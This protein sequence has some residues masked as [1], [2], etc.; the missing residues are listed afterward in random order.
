M[1]KS[2]TKFAAIILIIAVS[3]IC[4]PV[5]AVGVS[6]S[7]LELGYSPKFPSRITISGQTV[8]IEGIPQTSDYRYIWLWFKV[9]GSETKSYSEIVE[10]NFDGTAA[11]H[12]SNLTSGRYYLELFCAGER[13]VTYSSIVWGGDVQIQWYGNS[14]AFIEPEMY[15]HNVIVS[16][17]KRDDLAALTYYLSQSDAIQS[18]NAEIKQLANQLT[19]GITDNYEKAVVIHDWLCN[20]I[21]YDYDAYYKRTGYGDSSALGT[22]RSKIS[23]CEG[24]A[25]LN[26][27]LLRAAG[28]PAK[29]VIGYALG[30]ST[31]GSWPM[32]IDPNNDSNHAWNEAYVD[33]RWIIIDATWGSNNTWE[34]G[35]FSNNTGLRG[36]HYFDISPT[37][38]AADHSIK[39]YS[40]SSINSYASSQ[41]RPAKAFLGKV[42]VNSAFYLPAMLY[43]IDGSNYVKLRDI[44]AM[45]SNFG[46]NLGVDYEG[47]TSTII[48]TSETKYRIQGTELSG[49]P[50][51]SSANATLPELKICYD[52]KMLYLRAYTIEGSTY[53]R[54]RELGELFNFDVDYDEDTKMINVNISERTNYVW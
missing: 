20:N 44:A 5:L 41:K 21:Y 42:E 38:F 13:Y 9:P 25:N 28:I 35:Q 51:K 19:R 49:I 18:D 30:T 36:H 32:N 45:L 8:T 53:F 24:Y 27:A 4:V 50:A 10:R 14:G 2:I 33:G 6:V 15:T 39:N 7:E 54:L 43:T 29:K 17:G 34:Y 37:L 47:A 3:I 31:D 40:E 22:L 11:F 12:I 16:N 26:A 46:E 48:I 1:K 52:G 23:V